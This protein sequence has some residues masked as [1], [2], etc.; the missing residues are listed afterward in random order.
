MFNER[1][2]VFGAGHTADTVRAALRAAG[3]HIKTPYYSA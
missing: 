3:I 1:A 2:L